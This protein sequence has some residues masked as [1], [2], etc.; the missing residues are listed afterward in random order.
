LEK[1]LLANQH[2][3]GVASRLEATGIVRLRPHIVNL[4][5]EQKAKILA[6]VVLKSQTAKQS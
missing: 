4:Y 3:S 1:V 2:P 5:R 6:G